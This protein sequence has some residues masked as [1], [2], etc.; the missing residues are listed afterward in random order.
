MTAH[1]SHSCLSASPTLQ[2]LIDLFP[3]QYLTDRRLVDTLGAKPRIVRYE[4]SVRPKAG[5]SIRRSPTT[6]SISELHCDM[7]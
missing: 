6:R 3:L 7:A 1:A 4:S 5:V 2:V